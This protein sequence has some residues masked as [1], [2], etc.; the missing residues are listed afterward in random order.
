MRAISR[1][2]LKNR[3]AETRYW[4]F[5][6]ATEAPVPLEKLQGF[7]FDWGSSRRAKLDCGRVSTEVGRIGRRDGH[8][9]RSAAL[10]VRNAQQG[11]GA[12]L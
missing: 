6:P 4:N 5:H 1:L 10:V 12:N 2:T 8:Y 3:I 9:D 11:A 7:K